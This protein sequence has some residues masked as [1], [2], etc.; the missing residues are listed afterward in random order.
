MWPQKLGE[1]L[2]SMYVFGTLNY[3]NGLPE[4]SDDGMSITV[5]GLLAV[6]PIGYLLLRMVLDGDGCCVQVLHEGGVLEIGRALCHLARSLKS[7]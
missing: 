3:L 4:S 6:R 1:L 2:A 5:H 7:E